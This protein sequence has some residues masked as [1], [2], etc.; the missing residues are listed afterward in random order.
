MAKLGQR[1]AKAYQGIDPNKEPDKK[2][3]DGA[4]EVEPKPPKGP[5]GKV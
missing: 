4:K 2:G 1:I 5:A 3:G